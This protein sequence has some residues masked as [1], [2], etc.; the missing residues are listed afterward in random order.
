LRQS[1]SW[2]SRFKE[3]LAA[4]LDR[5]PR[6]RE[7]PPH[8]AARLGWEGERRAAR[9]LRKA[10]YKILY[11]NF[12]PLY[13][14]EV[15]LVCR[16]RGTTELVF[17]EVKTR[18][19]ESYGAPA[20]AVDWEKQRRIVQAASEWCALLERQEGL[21]KRSFRKRELDVTVR[22]DVIELLHRGGEWEIRHWKDA[23]TGEETRHPGS[24]P[25]IPGANRGD[26]LPKRGRGGGGPFRRRHGRG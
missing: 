4:L 24:M 21:A 18:S 19:S 7:E 10:G 9:F 5:R 23:F 3:T 25:L 17:V 15:D 2:C 16:V 1:A 20:D 8:T 26:A 14:G 13:G 12:R 22:F 6:L 11:R